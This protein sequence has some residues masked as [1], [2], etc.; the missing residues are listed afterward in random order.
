MIDML[1]SFF[2]ETHS[3]K[4]GTDLFADICQMWLKGCLFVE[5]HEHTSLPIPDIEDI[6]SK[7]VS[8]ELS[9][10]VGNIIDVIEISDNDIANPLPS[11]LLLQRRIKYGVKTETAV[12]VCEKI[13]NDRFLANLMA[14]RIGHGAI[15]TD[16]IVSVVKS[17]KDDILEILSVYPTYF[18]ERIKWMCKD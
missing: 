17:R 15:T 2:L 18:S 4:K 5:M 12:S 13:F 14:E 9:F 3:L 16:K 1:I 8:Y 11:L 10:F 6:C 7:S